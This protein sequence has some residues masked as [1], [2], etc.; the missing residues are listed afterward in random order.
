MMNNNS[1][2]LQIPTNTLDN[3]KLEDKIRLMLSSTQ[4]NKSMKKMDQFIDHLLTSS[5]IVLI[6]EFIHESPVAFEED[7]YFTLSQYDNI[8]LVTFEDEK[9]D[10]VFPVFTSVSYAENLPYFE[11][12]IPL[13]IPAMQVLEMVKTMDCNKLTLNYESSEMV[14]LDKVLVDSIVFRLI[15][16]GELSLQNTFM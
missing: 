2:A 8:P 13:I 6:S 7:G 1:D 12:Y 11:G 14:E 3:E 4:G 16:D 5:L 10:V 15:S 9:G